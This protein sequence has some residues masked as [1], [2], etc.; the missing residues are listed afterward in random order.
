MQ[1]HLSWKSRHEPNFL[2]VG[3]TDQVHFGLG[4]PPY[5]VLNW[6]DANGSWHMFR[7]GFRYDVNWHGY[8]FPTMALKRVRRP[9]RY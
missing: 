1:R 9:L 3:R 7:I 6:P 2:S 5:A 4:W 8:I